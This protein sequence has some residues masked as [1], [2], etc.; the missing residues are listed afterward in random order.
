MTAAK[1]WPQVGDA[2]VELTASHGPDDRD[3]VGRTLRIMNVVGPWIV[4]DDGGKYDWEGRFPMSEGRYSARRLMATTDPRVLRVYGRSHL[5]ALA[6][7]TAN[8]ANLEHKTPEDTVAALAR[9]IAL[10]DD[11]RR[12]MIA[13]MAEASRTEQE[14]SR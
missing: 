12:A 8:I 11:S 10:A 5:S 3:Q 6:S 14:S 13:L 1:R 4:T 2:A 9:I 7:I